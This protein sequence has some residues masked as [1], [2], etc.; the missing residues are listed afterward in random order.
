MPPL[1]PAARGSLRLF[2]RLPI[3]FDCSASPLYDILALRLSS[4]GRQAAQH[5]LYEL[6]SVLHI[7]FPLENFMYM[8]SLSL[9]GS[10]NSLSREAVALFAHPRWFSIDVQNECFPL[11]V[12]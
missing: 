6:A 11:F 3:L 2:L 1:R 5:C 4:A 10:P 9:H 7:F 12:N 8:S